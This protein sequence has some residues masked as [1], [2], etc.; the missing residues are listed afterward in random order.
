MSEEEV[1]VILKKLNTLI[2]KANGI[3]AATDITVMKKTIEEMKKILG[4]VLKVGT[5]I[6]KE[7]TYINTPACVSNIIF[8]I[9]Y[10]LSR[11]DADLNEALLKV[12][13][14]LIPFLEDC[15]YDFYFFTSVMGNKEK[16]KQHYKEEFSKM[17]GNH[18]IDEAIKTKKYKY[19]VSIVVS[20]YNHLDYTKRCIE[21]I[22]KHMPKDLNY[23]L[24]LLNNGSTDGTQKYFE[25]LK[26]TKIVHLKENILN[27]YIGIRTRV[28]EGR[29]LLEISNDVIVQVNYLENLLKCIRSDTKIAM[30]VPTTPGVGGNQCITSKDLTPEQGEAFAKTN[31]IS[32]PK[33]WRSV[34]LLYNPI[35][36]YR[37]DIVLSSNGIGMW[38]KYFVNT[39]GGDNGLSKR[40][41]DAGYKLILAEDTYCYHFGKVT[42][43]NI[44]D[45]SGPELVKRRFMDE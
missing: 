22:L 45:I 31:N 3:K 25:S 19:E 5:K 39:A 34:K 33:R 4:E 20:A 32:D 23:E 36:L 21:S 30:V 35:A 37:S 8:S 1:A 40:L 18:F 24:I 44:H 10:I 13:F 43:K 42:R 2:D 7:N 6:K 9:E 29:Y 27:S 28:C 17:V 16:E 41:I 14:E 11:L 38:D 26:P 15:Y 12:N